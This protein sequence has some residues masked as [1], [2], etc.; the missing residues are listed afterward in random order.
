MSLS[1]FVRRDV[2]K[3]FPAKVFLTGNSLMFSLISMHSWFGAYQ[4]VFAFAYQTDFLGIV[5]CLRDMGN[6]PVHAAAIALAM[7]IWIGDALMIYRCFLLWQRRYAVIILPTLLFISSVAIHSTNFWWGSQ[8]SD[9]SLDRAI[10][11]VWPLLNVPFPLYLVQNLLTTG[12]ILFK[13]WSRYRQTKAI[14]ILA[15]HTPS[16]ISIMRIIVESA[17]LHTTAMLVMLILRIRDN[18][19]HI[20]LMQCILPPTIG[21][22]FVLMTIRTHALQE[23]AKVTPGP[24]SLMPTWL[25]CERED[26]AEDTMGQ[27]RQ[28]ESHPDCNK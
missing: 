4:L 3:T 1:I 13:I 27:G 7:A 20:F 9:T 8:Q 12:L 16:L 23:D 28:A 2:L 18:T 24:A 25:I 19:N 15:L 14:G 5:A 21:A 11:K 10:G 17:A 26:R 22:V 6:V